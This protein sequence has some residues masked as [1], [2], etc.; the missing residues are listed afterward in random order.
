MSQNYEVFEF[1]VFVSSF[2]LH[3]DFYFLFAGIDKMYVNDDSQ[4]YE[5]VELHAFVSS[6]VF[7]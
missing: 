1:H 7:R 3:P 4:N 2:G 5:V 6:F